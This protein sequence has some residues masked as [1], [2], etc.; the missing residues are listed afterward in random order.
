MQKWNSKLYDTKHSFVTEYGNDVLQLLEPKAGELILDLGCG[1]GAL[2][3]MIANAGAEVIGIDA[4]QSMIDE[5]K[6]NYP[7]I[8][9]FCADG[10]N[11]D[12]GRTFDAVFSNA[13][14]HW[15]LEPQKVIHSVNKALKPGG[16]FVFEMGGKGNV[17]NLLQAV[18]EGARHVGITDSGLVNFYPS[19]AKYSGLLENGG[20]EVT[21]AQLFARPTVL[22]GVDGLRNW[23]K[24]FR[25]G[26]VEKIDASK[27]EDFFTHVE[28]LARPL[29]LQNGTWVADYVRLR[30]IAIKN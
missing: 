18:D 7:N 11:F 24:M 21:Y 13:A 12:L 6:R 19:I 3:N 5:A 17:S 2:T 26:L 10:Q 30:M 15:M 14:L 22:E 9:F 1:T 16:R 23:I 27:L 20:F 28:K 4:S 8:Q 29:L 25:A